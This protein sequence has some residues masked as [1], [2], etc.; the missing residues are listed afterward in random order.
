MTDPVLEPAAVAFA[1]DTSQKPFIYELGPEG[2]RTALDEVQAGDTGE[3]GVE[4]T[5]TSLDGVSVRIVRRA[6]AAEASPVILYTH[7]AGW[8][9]GDARSHGRLIAELATRTNAAVV[10]PN[11]DRSPEVRFPIAIEQV[12]TVAAALADSGADHGLDA[13]RLVVAGDS[14]GGN[15]T[16]ALTLLAKQRGGVEI[17]AQVLLYPVTDADFTTGSYEQFAEGYFLRKEGMEWFWDQYL[18]DAAERTQPLASPLRAS[19]EEL[20]E[21]PSAL[22]ITGEAD[23]LRDEG[24]AYAAKLRAAGVTVMSVRFG[25][26][27]HDFLMV[28]S[29][30]SSEA[31]IGAMD[32]ATAYISRVLRSD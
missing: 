22:V 1:E 14:V 24:E 7:G 11:Y 6:D 32:L 23:V 21:L 13:N 26:I 4:I 8:V 16:A 29:L 27:I 18:P 3:D 12:Y 2:G 5:D 25:G 31:A 10:F 28:N 15:M 19:D 17:A 9:F 30:R 20:R